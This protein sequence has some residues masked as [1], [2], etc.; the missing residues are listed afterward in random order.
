MPLW[1]N[2]DILED[3][4][5]FEAPQI[6]LDLSDAAVLDVATDTFI[7]PQGHGFVT[8]DYIRFQTAGTPPS[9]LVTDTYYYII[10]TSA[11]T[12]QLAANDTDAANGTQIVIAGLGTGTADIVHKA[13]T[14]I[15]FVSTEESQVPSNIAKGIDTPGWI[16]HDTYVDSNTVTR[17]KT[18]VIVPMKV[19]QADT[20]GDLGTESNTTIEDTTVADS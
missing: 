13:P 7:Y 1:G 18:E 14:N 12:F 10:R 16:R 11:T 8:G 6:T 4:P 17:Y 15:F 5:K 2:Q 3:A 9:P 19:A 20:G